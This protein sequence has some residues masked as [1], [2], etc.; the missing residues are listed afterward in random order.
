MTFFNK[1]EDVLKI[2]LT[3]HG[4]KLLSQGKLMPH[5]YAFLD[6]DILYDAS[7]SGVSENNSQMKNRI[8]SETPYLKPQ[9]NYKGVDSKKSDDDN[10]L[11]QTRFLQQKLGTNSTT[12][13]RTSAWR[14]TTLLGEITNSTD[15][16]T[17]SGT[18]TM[19]I[20]QL[21]IE[22]NYTMSVKQRN[23][24]QGTSG[25]MIFSRNLPS[26][27]KPDGSYLEIEEEQILMEI[28]EKNS[29][30]HRESYEVEVY[31]YE[32]D[33]Q[34]I[35]RKLKFYNQEAEI[36]NDILVLN[37]N[38]TILDDI[39]NTYVEYYLDLFVDKEI[40]NEDICMGVNRLKVKDIFLDLEVDCPDRSLSDLINPNF[41]GSRV[42][43]TDLEDC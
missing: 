40:S 16:L 19:N 11:E 3:P 26:F 7:N 39:D 17:G 30:A 21:E 5:Y 13:D 29:D 6:D 38:N 24:L 31:V 35:D 36:M 43:E 34:E 33:E 20:P 37:Q 22:L 25:G 12:S 8:I 28:F 15:A 32:Q 1:K 2:E 9:T 42:T 23:D 10:K 27:V 4:R 41:Y 18:Q 14:I